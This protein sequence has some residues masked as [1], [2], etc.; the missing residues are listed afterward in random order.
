MRLVI[1]IPEDNTKEQF[2]ALL[3]L[4]VS[5]IRKTTNG[6]NQSNSRVMTRLARSIISQVHAHDNSQTD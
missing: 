5:Q 3:H 2:V 6:N 1:D 4:A